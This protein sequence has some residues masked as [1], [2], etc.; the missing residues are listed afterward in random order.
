[1]TRTGLIRLLAHEKRGLLSLD[2]SLGDSGGGGGG[3]GVGGAVGV[4]CA[5]AGGGGL[6][7]VC[8]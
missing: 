6:G 2:W 3:G 5:L 7:V 1:M 8:R 4:D